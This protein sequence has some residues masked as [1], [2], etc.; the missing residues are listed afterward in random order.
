MVALLWEEVIMLP[1]Y[2]VGCVD[3]P[4]GSDNSV[5]AGAVNVASGVSL[6]PGN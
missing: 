5:A 4:S 2:V 3:R 6:Y 1:S